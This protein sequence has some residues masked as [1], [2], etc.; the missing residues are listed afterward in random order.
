MFTNGDYQKRM[1][2]ER[3]QILRFFSHS[4]ILPV[5]FC[6]AKMPLRCAHL[7]LWLFS[8]NI[9]RCAPYPAA[10]LLISSSYKASEN[11]GKIPV[12]W[13]IREPMKQ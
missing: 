13:K 5:G 9:G 12:W 3:L 11:A 1:E 4:Y 2:L 8:P 6:R 10:S 7:S